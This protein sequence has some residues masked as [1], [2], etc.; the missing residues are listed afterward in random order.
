MRIFVLAFVLGAL[1]L[2]HASVLP[3]AR[4]GIV[5]VAALLG[6]ALV[7]RSR[8]PLRRL[9]LFVAGCSLGIAWPA[10]RAEMRLADALPLEW[11]GRD[12]EVV[13]LVADLPQPK[14]AGTRFMFDIERTL[15]P[16]AR[17]PEHVSLTWFPERG[18]EAAP[19]PKLV[20]GE[21]WHLTVRLTRVRGLANPHTFDLEPWALERG[22]RA[23][24]YVRAR[25]A[26]QRLEAR[27]EGWPYTLHRW[28]G[29]IRE[30]M[31]ERLGEARLRGVLVALAIGDQ[32]SIAADDWDVFWRTGVG[33][34]MSISGLHITML[35]A[36]AFA[37]AW[38]AWARVPALVLRYPARKAATVAGVACALAYTLMTGYAVPAQRT[39][40]MLATVGACL[41]ADRHGSPSRV[42]A[43]AA[44]VVLA[45]D[46]WAVLSPGFWLSFGAVAA[47]FYAL[48]LR[49]GRPGKLQAAFG[50]QFA[51]TVGMLPMLVALF[52]QVSLV[53]PLANAFAIPVVSLVVVPLTIA[54]AF[55][56]LPWLLDAAHA[57]MGWVMVPLEVLAS[58]PLAML[59]SAEPSP[60]AVASAAVGCAW[61]LAPRGVP[62]RSAGVAWLA[63]LFTAAAP[64]PGPGEAWLDVLDVGNGLAIVVR[65]RSHAFMY[66]TGPSW[67]ADADSGNRIAVPFLRG[68]GVDRLEGVVV[69]HA[70]DDHSGGA[71]S[72]ANAR[73]PAWLLSTLRPDNGLHA[74]FPLSLR[75]QAGT[76]WSWDGVEFEILHPAPAVY[77]QRDRRKEND[78]GC[79]MRIAARG[80]SALL[81]ADVEARSEAEMVARDAPALRST[82]MLVPHHGSRTSSSP[83]FLDAVGAR[84]ALLSV[85]YR[86]RF[87]HPNEAVMSRYAQRGVEVHRTDREGALHVV[88]PGD[89]GGAVAVSGYAASAVRY[90]SAPRGPP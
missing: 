68:E 16:G 6:V 21:R 33:H 66:D 74:F 39:F 18:G 38:R 23:A 61:L 59:E 85:G 81:T 52:Q 46:P 28:R 34:L 84:V 54:G 83:A 82:V 24:G 4:P 44:F 48:S 53:S 57:L 56:P 70:D 37:I 55:L 2:Q 49:A 5:G 3:D 86:N 17:V 9:L 40:F 63:P 20:P 80:A 26:P 45:I 72:I 41:L 36:L 29:E 22:I 25:P 10:W 75:C 43:L 89:A 76:R 42:L 69:T 87:H 8:W 15:T 32:D 12:I 27:A 14:E 7:P 88:L 51:V 13:G 90:W 67:N 78:R 30:G 73:E 11:E 31:L 65:T 62:L 77:A 64:L 35:A 58:L 1:V 50:E 47:I 79:V 60:W 19:L 71:A